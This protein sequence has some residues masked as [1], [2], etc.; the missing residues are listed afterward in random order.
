MASPQ[1]EDGYTKI[2]NELFDAILKYDF[3]KLQ[4]KV[5][6]YIIRKLY[7]WGRVEDHMSSS[8]I[9]SATGLDGGN[10]R[11]TLIELKAKNVIKIDGKLIRVEKNYDLWACQNNTDLR[12]VSPCQNNTEACQN[13]TEARQNNT[14]LNRV[15]T[16]RKTVLKQHGNKGGVGGGSL[17]TRTVDKESERKEIKRVRENF[18]EKTSPETGLKTD[19]K[20]PQKSE[21]ILIIPD[22]VNREKWDAYLD[23]RR[24]LK[25]IAH[26][27]YAHKL[28]IKELTKLR[29]LGND[30]DEVM[31]RSIKN[32]W[33]DFYPI[34]NGG[35]HGK[36][37]TKTAAQ[38]REEVIRNIRNV[39]DISWGLSETNSQR[40]DDIALDQSDFREI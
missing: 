21:Q 33:K 17:L 35:N 38:H 6:L 25:S 14:G 15:K 31:D 30:P 1:V 11:R 2:A 22:W 39:D 37:G 18:V 36:P 23:V 8:E 27:V 19:S 29:D 12:Q 10:V 28:L 32:S 24:G 4:L 40:G 13:N 5:L 7:G 9:A 16:T 3:S 26:T 34:K 20:K